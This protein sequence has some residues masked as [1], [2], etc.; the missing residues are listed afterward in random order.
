MSS[1]RDMHNFKK[2]N[3]K[4][5]HEDRHR[6]WP[7]RNKNTFSPTNR[8][9]QREL[10]CNKPVRGQ[11]MLYILCW[12]GLTQ[13]TVVYLHKVVFKNILYYM[14]VFAA[15]IYFFL[16]RCIAS[17]DEHAGCP[18]HGRKPPAKWEVVVAMMLVLYWCMSNKRICMFANMNADMNTR[19]EWTKWGC[20]L[21]KADGERQNANASNF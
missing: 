4:L 6:Q 12:H 1:E 17:T 19:S 20:I 16:K 11:R 2:K 15:Y 14:F 18:N 8:A 7:G 21:T 5:R 13:H 9:P 3:W 10:I